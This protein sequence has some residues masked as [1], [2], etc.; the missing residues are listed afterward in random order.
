MESDFD[1]SL[2]IKLTP[3]GIL[4]LLAV[5]FNFIRL[6]PKGVKR[7]DNALRNNRAVQAI[8]NYFAG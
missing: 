3:F 4:L 7:L 6:D 1:L 8:R 2:L 5:Y